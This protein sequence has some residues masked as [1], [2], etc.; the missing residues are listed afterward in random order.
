MQDKLDGGD[1]GYVM[2]IVILLLFGQPIS[3]FIGKVVG[4]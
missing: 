4:F 2:A 3:E 1:I